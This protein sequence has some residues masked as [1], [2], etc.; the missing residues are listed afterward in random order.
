MDAIT[1][2]NSESLQD[3]NQPSSSKV[4]QY[5]FHVVRPK[6]VPPP[7]P[8]FL[9]SIDLCYSK[10]EFSTLVLFFKDCFSP[11]TGAKSLVDSLRSSLSKVLVFYPVL[12]GR[13]RVNESGRIE[14][15]MNGQGVHFVESK[16]DSSF[17]DWQDIRQCPLDIDLSLDTGVVNPSDVPLIKFHLTQFHCGSIAIAVHFLHIVLDGSSLYNFLNAWAKVHRGS[18]LFCE[19]FGRERALLA[20][21]PPKV[22]APVPFI[23]DAAARDK[24]IDPSNIT[25]CNLVTLRMEQAA[26][27]ACKREAQTGAFAYNGGKA[28]GFEAVLSLLWSSILRAQGVPQHLDTAILFSINLRGQ[29]LAVVPQNYFGNAVANCQV[30]ASRAGDIVASDLSYAA[31]LIHKAKISCNRASVQSMLDWLEL[32]SA[33][34]HKELHWRRG[35]MSTTM[36]NFHMYGLDFGWRGGALSQ[37]CF[38]PSKVPPH[39]PFV[40][41]LPSPRPKSIEIVIGLHHQDREVLLQDHLFTRYFSASEIK[42]WTGDRIRRALRRVPK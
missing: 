19:S 25:P 3:C 7:S 18:T 28:T 41:M 29:K 23:I 22:D 17:Q 5:A 9:S 42:L 24:Q 34:L 38:L 1:K 30:H 2:V 10:P 13:L 11:S 12:A 40:A 8:H 16:V 27:D 6:K 33:H 21:D 14:V 36:T 39:M 4:V 26:I 37:L 15:N 31:H 20:R 32:N 35:I